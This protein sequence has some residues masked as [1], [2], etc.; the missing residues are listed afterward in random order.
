MHIKS[1]LK[2][3]LIRPLFKKGKH[4]QYCLPGFS[5]SAPGVFT[6][7][8][9]KYESVLGRR[10]AGERLEG[11]R[12]VPSLDEAGFLRQSVPGGLRDQLGLPSLRL[13]GATQRLEQNGQTPTRRTWFERAVPIIRCTAQ[14]PH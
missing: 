2:T 5:R 12:L 3:L 13:S 14:S 10:E 9:F 1:T 4:G 8:L 6:R 11:G 7:K